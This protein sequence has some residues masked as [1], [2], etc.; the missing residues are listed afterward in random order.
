MKICI[1]LPKF[2]RKAIGGYK[3]AFEYANRLSKRDA[4]GS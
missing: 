2:A 3:I 4:V 1:V